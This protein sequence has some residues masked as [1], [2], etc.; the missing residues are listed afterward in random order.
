V[1]VYQI[2]NFV[3][4]LSGNQELGRSFYFV[5]SKEC[6]I[7]ATLPEKPNTMIRDGP[8]P[9]TPQLRTDRK[10]TIPIKSNEFV[11]L[12]IL[13]KSYG[14]T[15]DE[16]SDAELLKRLRQLE[17]ESE[18][19]QFVVD[20]RCRANTRAEQRLVDAKR[21]WREIAARISPIRD[22]VERR[23]EEAR[24]AQELADWQNSDAF[25]RIGTFFESLEKLDAQTEREQNG[26][27]LFN[28]WRPNH[29]EGFEELRVITN[30]MI[31]RGSKLLVVS[32][33]TAWIK[34]KM[35][36]D[37]LRLPQ[38]DYPIALNRTGEFAKGLV[39]DFFAIK[40]PRLSLV[41]VAH[42]EGIAF[43]PEITL[44]IQIPTSAKS[45]LALAN[46]RFGKP[47]FIKI[48][49]VDSVLPTVV[50]ALHRLQEGKG[51]PYIYADNPDVT[52]LVLS[53]DGVGRTLR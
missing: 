45:N 7:N 53:G 39:K 12:G 32:G 38:N 29:W 27:A 47:A 9:Q 18:Q 3:G 20:R 26:V 40:E 46:N 21:R 44:G 37:G 15:F 33:S 10:A 17:E 34:Y 41:G 13:W 35:S 24:K 52:P 11:R 28:E 43:S 16:L 14:M 6:G 31:L 19:A 8:A 36:G 42:F 48:S 49:D 30:I 23:Q 51:I 4:K 25:R 22:E 5:K 2:A 50:P 1:T